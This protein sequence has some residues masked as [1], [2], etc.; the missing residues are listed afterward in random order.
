MKEKNF[1]EIDVSN[2]MANRIAALDRKSGDW[3]KFY[4]VN[5]PAKLRENRGP[6]GLFNAS[7]WKQLESGLIGPVVLIPMKIPEL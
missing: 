1:L 5:F 6:D 3:K 2:L 7:Q 4:N